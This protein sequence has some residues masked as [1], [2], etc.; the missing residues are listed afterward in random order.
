MSDGIGRSGFHHERGIGGVLVNPSFWAFGRLSCRAAV[1]HSALPCS[2]TSALPTS[3]GHVPVSSF[4]FS[5]C[6]PDSAGRAL[7]AQ[8]FENFALPCGATVADRV[9]D[10]PSRRKAAPT[11]SILRNPNCRSGFTPRFRLIFSVLSI[12]AAKFSRPYSVRSHPI[13]SALRGQDRYLVLT[14][15]E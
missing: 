4:F 6:L 1:R 13:S 12:V 9:P 5:V 3:E 11:I 7:V 8:R 10:R 2:A 15:S 14:G